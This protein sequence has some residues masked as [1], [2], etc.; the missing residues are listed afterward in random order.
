MP[1]GPATPSGAAT[2]DALVVA[3]ASSLEGLRDD[4]ERLVQDDT[5]VFRSWEWAKAWELA[6][7]AGCSRSRGPAARWWASPGWQSCG[8]RLCGYS[9]SRGRVARTRS[10]RSAILAIGRLSRRL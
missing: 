7:G 6:A 8:R 10:A 1:A 2:A 5:D 4:W 3:E 9:A